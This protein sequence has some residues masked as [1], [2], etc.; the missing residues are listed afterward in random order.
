MTAGP[1]HALRIPAAGSLVPERSAARS[2]GQAIRDTGVHRRRPSPTSRCAVQGSRTGAEARAR[3]LPGARADGSGTVSAARRAALLRR[4][5]ASAP[6]VEWVAASGL[7]AA[8]CSGSR[9]VRSA[10]SM[11]WRSSASTPRSHAA[12][13]SSS[14]A[15][16]TMLVDAI[17]SAI[18]DWAPVSAVKARAWQRS[19]IGRGGPGWQGS[20]FTHLREGR[21]L[22]AAPRGVPRPGTARPWSRRRELQR[23]ERLRRNDGPPRSARG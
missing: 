4:S 16:N 3:G 8:R 15:V 11:C 9:A 5:H 13:C 18:A 14:P 19:P 12:A 1:S 20:R 22:R 2:L 17:P 21:H 6:A 7:A 23:S 10:R